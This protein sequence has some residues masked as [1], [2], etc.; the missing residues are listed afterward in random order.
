MLDRPMPR[1]RTAEQRNGRTP[2]AATRAPVKALFAS[3]LVI[4]RLSLLEPAS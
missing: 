3:T 1:G 2:P 4:E